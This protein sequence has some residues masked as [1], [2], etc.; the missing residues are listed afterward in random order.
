LRNT[1]PRSIRRTKQDFAKEIARV[2]RLPRYRKAR[3]IHIVCDNLNT[4]NEKS[5]TE[6]FGE[7]AKLILERIKFHHTSKHASWLNM[8]E[9]ELSILSRQ[10]LKGRIGTRNLLK[11][12]IRTSEQKRNAAQ[13]M[14]RWKLTKEDA[15]RIF[16]CNETGN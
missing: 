2:A 5:L 10:A 6:T 8:A 1:S 12:R 9:I 7:N 16:K 13:A 14:I 3:A 11:E 15:R 4:H